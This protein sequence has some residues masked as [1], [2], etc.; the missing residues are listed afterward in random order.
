MSVQSRWNAMVEASG[1]LLP[2]ELKPF[3]LDTVT[4]LEAGCTVLV[5]VPTNKGKSLIQLHGAR[6]MGGGDIISLFVCLF[7]C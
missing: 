3:Q 7:V 5:A 6:I 4:Q 2:R 1:G